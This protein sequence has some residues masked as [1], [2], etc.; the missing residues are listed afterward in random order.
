MSLDKSP[1]KIQAMFNKISEGYD[2]I[3]NL[4][5]LGTQRCIKKCCIS[6]LDIKPHESVIDLCCGTGDMSI[7]V[8][9]QQP[10][11]IVTGLD[12]S[13]KMLEIA[14]KRVSDIKFLLSDV[15]VLP[16]EDSSIDYVIMSFGLR[17]INVPEKTI[18]E[19]Y[20]VL[21]PN[22]KFLHLDFGEKNFVNSLFDKVVPFFTGLLTNNKEAYNYLIE[23]KKS[24]LSPK[25]LIKDFE[26]KGFILYKRIDFMFKTI[27]CQIM[28]K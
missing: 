24:F 14:K 12:F 15:S 4:I 11:A 5:S 27:S 6:Q 1:E 22:G 21:K 7:Y 25:D 16:F 17:N 13:Q 2:F 19:V 10:Y 28:Q 8:K 23:S 26:L 9:K 3:N 18:E 20:R